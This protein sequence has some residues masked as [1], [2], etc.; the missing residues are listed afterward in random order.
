M[1]F[2]LVQMSLILS[3]V[4]A[5]PLDGDF[6]PI[7]HE[8]KKKSDDEK[9]KKSPEGKSKEKQKQPFFYWHFLSERI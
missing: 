4:H 3:D 1:L 9:K 5:S 2:S 7:I 6:S 8:A